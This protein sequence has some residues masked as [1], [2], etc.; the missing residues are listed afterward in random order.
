M[1]MHIYREK[2][3]KLEQK[4]DV[5]IEICEKYSDN[6]HIYQLQA[7]KHSIQTDNFQL[8]VVGEFSVGKSTLVNALI[9]DKVLPSDPNP[10][11]IMLN[12]IKNGDKEVKYKI[13]YKDGREISV[14]REEF[15]R[16]VA[17]NE[18]DKETKDEIIKDYYYEEEKNFSIKNAEIFVENSFG[19][20]G[21]DIVDTPGMN[22]INTAREEVTLN[23]IPKSDAAIVVCS[24]IHP[25]SKS[26]M[27]FIK[28]QLVDQQIT[29][30]FVAVNYSDT[31]RTETARQ[32]MFELFQEK[33]SDIVPKD[34]IF[35]VSARDALKY[36]RQLAGDTYKKP[37]KSY[38]KTGFDKFEEQVLNY[39][40]NDRG[41]IK[42]QRYSSM[43]LTIL[44]EIAD[45]TLEHRKNAI[46]LSKEQLEEEVTRLLENLNVLEKQYSRELEKA[47]NELLTKKTDFSKKYEKRLQKMG[48]SALDEVMNYR[49]TDMNEIHSIISNTIL[50]HKIEIKNNFMAHMTS[51]IQ[52]IIS[53]HI[54]VFGEEFKAIGISGIPITV[55]ENEESQELAIYSDEQVLNI[56]NSNKK[57]KTSEEEIGEALVGAAIAFGI[58]LIGAAIITNPA[59]LIGAS[60]IGKMFSSNSNSSNGQELVQDDTVQQKPQI[61]N[62]M[63]KNV[64]NT[65]VRKCYLMN[66]PEKVKEFKKEYERN[67]YGII[68]NLKENCNTQ[69]DGIK[70]QYQ[71]ELD[72]KSDE[73]DQYEDKIDLIR[74]DINRIIDL[75]L[76]CGGEF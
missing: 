51:E 4:I 31:L 75:K 76:W 18:S 39:L 24:A 34:R 12:V 49:G 61:T 29:K 15:E 32:S 26:E 58:G 23:Y 42:L 60:V 52:E 54:K 7:I 70:K 62:A 9:G 25:L 44:N 64:Y 17:K 6:D 56:I 45:V 66:I 28:S 22:D 46:M 21:I 10:T 65:E 48:N 14:G 2:L 68:D 47:S 20:M 72:N 37:V 16:M 41:N 27:D 38:E 59:L 67:I 33:L 63:I 5:A 40:A 73:R 43:F 55:I 1:N 57:G 30:L 69:L 71:E 8:I 53:K 35:L 50:T 19:K 36:K 3:T 13:H 74:F 11:T